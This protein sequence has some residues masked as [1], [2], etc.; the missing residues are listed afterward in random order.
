MEHEFVLKDLIDKALRSFNF[1]ESIVVDRVTNAYRDAVGPFLTKLT[2][3]V[4]YEVSTHTL[5]VTL[6]SPAL[7]NELTYKTTD[8]IEA[9][10]SRIGRAEVKRIVLC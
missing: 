10:N 6:A 4:H 9:I 7:K 5:K 1:D 2:R 3:A 8:L